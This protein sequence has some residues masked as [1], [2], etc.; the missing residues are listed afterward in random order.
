MPIPRVAIVGRPNAGKSSLMN[1]IAGA[2]VSIV[3][4]TP[5]VTRDRVA[6]IVDLRPPS[7]QMPVKP[8]EFVDTGG[9][10]V[11]TAEGARFDESI[12]FQ[13]NEA[14]ESADLILFAIDCQ[15]GVTPADQVIAQMLRSGG[16]DRR[17]GKHPKAGTPAKKIPEIRIIAT[18]CDGP[19]WEAHAF[20]AAGLGFGEPLMCSAKNNYMRRDFLDALY[21]IL[22]EP[23]PDEKRPRA[24]LMLAII[25][26]RNAGKSTLVNTLAGEQRVI[27]SEIAGTTR[28]AVD[29]RF[30][31]DGRSLVAIDTAGLRRKKSFQDAIEHYAFDR[32]QRAVERADVILLLLDATEK[33]S[34]VDEQLAALA[35]RSYKPTIVVVTKWDAAEGQADHQGRQATPER[36]EEYI[37]KELRA[38]WFAPIS[39]VA[40]KTGRNVRN[41]I[42]LAFEMK[43]QAEER[44]TTGKL[45]RLVR[46]IIDTRGPTD[47]VGTQAKV[48]YVA[49]T[50]ICPPTITM[51]VNHP[52]LFRPNYLRF[53]MNRFREELPF[54]EIPMRVVV[55]ARRQR[56]GDL[57]TAG[58]EGDVTLKRGRKGLDEL[59]R[60]RTQELVGADG[61]SR[62][63]IPSD[64]EL[65]A[66]FDDDLSSDD[67]ALAAQMLG[68]SEEVD[69]GYDEAAEFGAFEGGSPSREEDDHEDEAGDEP[70]PAKA[71]APA[72]RSQASAS[73]SPAPRMPAAKPPVK[74]APPGGTASK[75]ARTASGGRKTSRAAAAKK[76]EFKPDRKNKPARSKRVD[77]GRM[78]GSRAASKAK[79]AAKAAP[80]TAKGKKPAKR[81]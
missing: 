64:A 34:Q 65:L 44:V 39:F 60:R 74:P 73:K 59:A 5:G 26:K 22:P 43:Q 18:K 56:E 3:D 75:P 27:V 23:Q 32:A 13:I 77:L 20:E 51:V 61:E 19:K 2:K 6:A 78:K 72:A 7:D 35:Q 29:V 47:T 48:Y 71:A 30:E 21:E 49:Q 63:V 76:S 81:R 15:Q 33:I 40:G 10:G 66:Q 42:N 57:A 62:G 31:M 12:E 25:G 1:M 38:M 9:F 67:A 36:Y 24:D 68:E 8:V 52:E 4:P 69:T 54:K 28:D 37:R 14:V 79:A 53:L 55:R 45:N 17:G 80:K 70:A 11:Y 41:T 46:A 58:D 16:F 50:G